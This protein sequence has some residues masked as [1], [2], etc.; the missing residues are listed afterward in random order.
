MIVTGPINRL[1]TSGRGSSPF[2]CGAEVTRFRCVH[3]EFW[4]TLTWCTRRCTFKPP[5]NKMMMRFSYGCTFLFWGPSFGSGR[6][7]TRAERELVL[8]T[9]CRP[10]VTTTLGFLAGRKACFPGT[11]TWTILGARPYPSQLHSELSLRL[12]VLQRRGRNWP[13]EILDR[14]A[15]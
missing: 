8:G 14:G 15:K 9:I 2:H 3:L 12:R 1:D 13:D 7:S 6:N 11:H 4:G 10:G 5:E